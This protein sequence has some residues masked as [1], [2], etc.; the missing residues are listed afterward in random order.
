MNKKV[1][2]M[3]RI[4]LHIVHTG[5]LNDTG[6]VNFG[7]NDTGDYAK[8]RGNAGYDDEEESVNDDAFFDF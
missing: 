4:R 8:Y 2:V 3:P 1:Y 5:Y 7:S 6:G